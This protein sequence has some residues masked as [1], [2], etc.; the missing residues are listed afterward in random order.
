MNA[1]PGLSGQTPAS[2]TRQRLRRGV[3]LVMAYLP[4]LL[5]GM[6][7]MLTYWLVRHTPEPLVSEP[8]R[9]VR[10]VPDYFM[11]DFSLKVYSASGRLES[12][13]LGERAEHFP[14]TDAL[15]VTAPRIR[16]TG[17]QGRLSQ[18]TALKA[19]TTPEGQRVELVGEALLRRDAGVDA[20]GQA[21]PAIELRS[22]Y[23]FFDL[24][25]EQVKTH[26]AVVFTRGADRFSA[27][28]LEYDHTR[29]LLQLSG[30]VRGFLTSHPTR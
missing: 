20:S 1:L 8:D 12:E 10:H 15:Q 5:M 19:I 7:A 17:A 25:T 14:D 23:L 22:E 9:P 16:K 13:V 11:R 30:R 28:A 29:G 3:D 26:Q 24:E 4:V 18:A 2:V 27:D 21:Y 6:L